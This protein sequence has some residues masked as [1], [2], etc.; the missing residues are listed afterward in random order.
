MRLFFIRHG[1]S[2]AN[3]DNFHQG[4][5]FDTELTEKGRQQSKI[6]IKMQAFSFYPNPQKDRFIRA[7][8]L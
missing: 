3:R 5:T 2:I 1:E 7:Y 6:W 8:L 4:R